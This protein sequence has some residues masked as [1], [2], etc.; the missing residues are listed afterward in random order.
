MYITGRLEALCNI[1]LDDSDIKERL[2]EERCMWDFRTNI[3]RS[4]HQAILDSQKRRRVP[5]PGAFGGDVRAIRFE[6]DV[7]YKM[8]RSNLRYTQS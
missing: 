4:K 1:S 7:T 6:C 3:K 8:H 2:E 5:S